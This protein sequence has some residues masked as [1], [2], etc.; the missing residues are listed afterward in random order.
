VVVVPR[1]WE[2]CT[3]V[4]LATGPSLTEDDVEFV[5]GKARVVAVNDA[6]RLAPWADVFY[7]SDVPWWARHHQHLAECQGMKFTVGQ[8]RTP[9][10]IKG[11][12]DVQV[13]RNTGT[14]GLERDPSAL[15]TGLN[16][17]YAAINLAVHFGVSR[18][19]LLG[20]NMS[21]VNGQRHF[22][23]NHKG[24][25]NSSDYNRFARK[26]ESLVEPL[27]TLGVSVTNCTQPT[28]LTAFPQKPLR[29]VLA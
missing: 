9:K 15:R 14:L 19:L 20:F 12:P 27:R 18:I 3:A 17:G 4:L 16:S 2:G 28:R 22:F 21:P 29:E 7:A 5:K 6:Y 1:S 11:L 8:S 13:L 25:N 26:F 24:L 23:G 10:P